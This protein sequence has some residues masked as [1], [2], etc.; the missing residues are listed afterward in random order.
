MRKPPP[1]NKHERLSYLLG[2]YGDGLL[3]EELFWGWMK[4]SGY[5][6]DD[7]DAWCEEFYSKQEAQA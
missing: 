1:A 2:A 4:Q 7:I 5:T 6:Q 3:T